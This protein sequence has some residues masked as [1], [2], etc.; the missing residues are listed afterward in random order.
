MSQKASIGPL[1]AALDADR[2]SNS[3]KGVVMLR[4][5]AGTSVANH[6]PSPSIETPLVAMSPRAARGSFRV[7]ELETPAARTCLPEED[8]GNISQT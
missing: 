1:P 3:Y 7:V 6:C 5:N 2:I 4:H 8:E